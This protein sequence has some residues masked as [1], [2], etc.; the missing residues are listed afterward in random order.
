MASQKSHSDEATD[1]AGVRVGTPDPPASAPSA[2]RP[3]PV[4]P[5]APA[6]SGDAAGVVAGPTPPT[7]PVEPRRILL[8]RFDSHGDI[9][10]VQ[11]LVSAVARRWPT[12][13][14]HLLVRPGYDQLAPMCHPRLVWRTQP[15]SPWRRYG[16]GEA[17]ALAA[18]LRPLAAERWDLVLFTALHRGLPEVMLAALLPQVPRFAIGSAVCADPWQ[19]SAL[20]RLGLDPRHLFTNAVPVLE[21]AH[22]TAKYNR[23]WQV[24]TGSRA[25]LPQPR[26]AVPADAESAATHL[27]QARGLSGR[28][29]VACMPAGT[30]QVAIKTWPPAAF[31]QVL[32]WLAHRRGLLPLLV[33]H[34]RERAWVAQV[35]GQ[36]AGAGVP[37]ATWL[38]RDG[39]LALLGALL[40]QCVLYLGNDSGP[41]HLAAAL[42]VPT[43][44]VFGGGT[45]PRFTAVGPGA[46]S[47]AARVP[48]A[49]CRWDC[50]FGEAH[51]LRAVSVADVRSAVDRAL[52]GLGV[53]EVRRVRAT[54]SVGE[55]RLMAQAARTYRLA[56]RR[57]RQRQE[58]IDGLL[59]TA[60]A[61]PLALPAAAAPSSPVSAA[62]HGFPGDD[63]P[64]GLE[65]VDRH[66]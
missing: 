16:D 3:P 53:S 31:A 26:W 57:L 37:V 27:L 34:E 5:R 25:A 48:C 66:A 61:A 28:Q 6:A 46:I 59:A 14:I 41:M 64:G 51:C 44:G 42:G 62:T 24:V 23:F 19:E 54:V 33:A 49:R 35:R 65:T 22:E 17:A 2:G 38:G 4:D 12:A 30:A 52:S 13:E 40:A 43:V 8:P 55:Q 60:P 32:V 15:H 47:V 20:A 63:E 36:V 10:L 56:Q 29:V 18:D 21:W 45:W 1:R 11:G 50:P 9:V 7:L 39:E 58:A